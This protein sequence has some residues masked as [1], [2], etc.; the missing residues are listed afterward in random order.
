[1][2]NSPPYLNFV[3]TLPCKTNTSVNVNFYNNA[4]LLS[5]AKFKQ[6]MTKKV[7]ISWQNQD[8]Q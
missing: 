1:M 5:D 3:A 2:K 7:T 8:N 4:V 6:N